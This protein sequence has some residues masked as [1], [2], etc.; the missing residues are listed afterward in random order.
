M[1]TRSICVVVGVFL[2]TGVLAP[3]RAEGSQ[4]KGTN[5]D[6]DALAQKLVTQCASIHEG[7][8]VLVTGGVRDIELLENIAVHIRRVGAFPLVSLYS[9]R[10]FRR[11]LEDVPAK[12]DAQSPALAL[13]LA[14]L[15]TAEIDVDFVETEGFLAKLP[16]ERVA[17]F[18]RSFLL[19]NEPMLQRNVRFVYLGNGLTPTSER[20]K[21]FGLSQGALSKIFWEGV[22]VDYTKLQVTGKAVRAALVSGKQVHI[23]HSNGTDLTMQIEGRRVFVSDGVISGEEMQAGGAACWVYLPAGEVYLAPVSGTAEGKVVVDRQLFQGSEILGLTLTFKAG[24][25]TSM[26]AQSGIEP[27]KALYDAAGPGKDVFA[28]VDIG[29]NP[30]V[31]LIPGSRMAACMLAGMVQIGIGNNTWAGGE[32]NV[33]YTMYSFLPGSTLEVDGRILVERGVLRF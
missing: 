2:A 15:I 8:L 18:W 17:T 30:N 1:K 27:L 3:P 10:M 32:N 9:E 6:Y 25:L 14:G 16:P 26:T 24:K 23:K 7:D 12:Y 21:L 20:A 28:S 4:Q 22:N 11:M 29:I 33:G 31:R 13:Q 19:V 5:V